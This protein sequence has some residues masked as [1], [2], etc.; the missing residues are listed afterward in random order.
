MAGAEAQARGVA[1][2]DLLRH[3]PDMVAEMRLARASL[4]QCGYNTALDLVVSGV[5]AL[6][7]PYETGTENEQRDRAERWP[8]SAS[9]STCASI[10][11]AATAGAGDLEEVLGF[12]PRPA[13]LALDGAQRSWRGPAAV[14]PATSHPGIRRGAGMTSSRPLGPQAPGLTALDR[15]LGDLESEGPALDV[16]IRDDDAGWGDD[17]LLTLIDLT[18]HVPACP[19]TWR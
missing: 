3:V 15:L 9:C 13:A 18:S 4:S 17:A 6:V 8:I 11:V 5:P 10:T 7:V 14:A 1:G 12:R 19:S 2:V 16:F